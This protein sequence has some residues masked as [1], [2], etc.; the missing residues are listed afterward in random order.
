MIS[1][2]KNQ[3]RV[4]RS[5]RTLYIKKVEDL[6]AQGFS[7]RYIKELN[8]KEQKEED[9]QKAKKEYMDKIIYD[10][11]Y[12]RIN[13]DRDFGGELDVWGNSTKEFNFIK[14]LGVINPYNELQKMKQEDEV[15]LG[16]DDVI[17]LLENIIVIFEQQKDKTKIKDNIITTFSSYGIDL[18]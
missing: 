7:Y 11:Y 14:E 9:K 6:S 10:A 5:K 18:L 12:K 13:S 4:I 16:V 15:V 2:V 3:D 8:K 1:D 17:K